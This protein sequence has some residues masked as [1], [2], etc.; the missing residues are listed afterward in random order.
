METNWGMH[1]QMK[2]D[3][4]E[5]MCSIKRL[6]SPLSG[7]KCDKMTSRDAVVRF[8]VKLSNQPLTVM[9]ERLTWCCSNLF[10]LLWFLEFCVHN[11][12]RC[13]WKQSKRGKLGQRSWAACRKLFTFT[14]VGVKMWYQVTF[15]RRDYISNVESDITKDSHTGRNIFS[16]FGFKV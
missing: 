9:L 16:Y 2:E 4:S 3:K 7:W 11:Y 6:S 15:R 10:L 8:S 1:V 5:I 13:P 12:A 14:I